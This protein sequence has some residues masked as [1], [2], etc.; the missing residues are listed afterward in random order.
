MTKNIRIDIDEA[1]NVL[2]DFSG[3]VGDTCL[4]DEAK[5]RELL[6]EMGLLVTVSKSTPKNKD[7]RIP[8]KEEPGLEIK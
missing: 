5:L 7:V 6:K 4:F 1:G 3:Y 2:A 8:I